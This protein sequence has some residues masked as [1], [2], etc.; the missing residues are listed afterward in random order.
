MYVYLYIYIRL[1]KG[2]NGKSQ[3]KNYWVYGICMYTTEQ[4]R[5]VMIDSIAYAPLWKT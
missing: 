2:N 3:N 4:Y 1:Y 5:A